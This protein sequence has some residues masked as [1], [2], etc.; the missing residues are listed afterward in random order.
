MIAAIHTNCKNRTLYKEV[1]GNVKYSIF[2]SA[3]VSVFYFLN[4]VD[5][6][7]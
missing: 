5:Y 7:E 6:N 2:E 4:Y 1:N 3:N